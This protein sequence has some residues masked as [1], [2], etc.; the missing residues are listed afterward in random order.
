MF[1]LDRTE[2]RTLQRK[3]VDM[4]D[5]RFEGL[6]AKYTCYSPAYVGYHAQRF[7]TLVLL[8]RQMGVDQETAIL[9]VGPT[10]TSILF[11]RELGCKVDSISFSPDEETPFGMNYQFDL[12]LAQER[13]DWRLDL[14]RYP[15][16]V[17]AEVIEHLYTH[18]TKVLAY[19]RELTEPGGY[20]IVQTPNALA[21]RKR[22]QFLLGKHPFEELSEVRESPNHYRESTLAELVRYAKAAGFDVT[23]A[24]V[25]NY[26]NPT[27][28][29]NAKKISPLLGMLY[30]RLNDWLPASMKQGCMVVLRRPADK[31]AS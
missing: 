16:I 19:L 20:V 6:P 5:E 14:G 13:E 24:G 11:Q 17:F 2:L 12:N 22:I 15:V 9:D 23:L 8:L 30:Y 29:Q 21:I 10:F 1:Q 4:R 18:P 26:F 25:F 3:I 28:R 7:A 31:L 27:F